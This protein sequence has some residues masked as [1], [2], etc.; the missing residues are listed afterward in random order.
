MVPSDKPVV[1]ASAT[2]IMCAMGVYSAKPTSAV[3]SLFVD[4]KYVS[5]NFSATGDY[6][7]DWI[8]PW[9]TS[10]TIT[11]T[12]SLTSASWTMSDAYKG[13]SVTC[14]TLAYSKN[15]IGLTSSKAVTA[16]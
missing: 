16:P 5:T 4:G 12:A 7:P 2:S 13:K 6:L 9:A 10:S 15:A 3:F 14:T 8:I 11:R 1:T